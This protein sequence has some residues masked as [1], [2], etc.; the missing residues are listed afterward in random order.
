MKKIIALLLLVTIVS[1]KG[2]EAKF[3]KRTEDARREGRGKVF[4]EGG[5]TLFGGDSEEEKLTKVVPVLWK[6]S[7]DTVSFMPLASVDAVGG[8]IVTDWYETQKA[9]G[10]RYKL[11]I[12]VGNKLQ[13]GGVKVSA[14]KQALENNTWRD[15]TVNK[16]FAESIE[17]KIYDNARRL[18]SQK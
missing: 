10:E 17:D 13:V 12:L 7:L 16:A 3:P 1:C 2:G 5:I 6:A 11:N 8:V 4:D 14:F 15:T 18:K 9:Q